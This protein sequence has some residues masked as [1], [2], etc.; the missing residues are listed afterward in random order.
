MRFVPLGSGS[1]G[2]ST[3]VEFAAARILVDAGLSARDLAARLRRVGVAPESID[4]ILLSHEHHDH[5]RGA[6]RFSTK[7]G[8]PVISAEET[9][10]AMDRSPVHFAEWIPLPEGEP[11]NLGPVRVEAFDVPHDAVRPVGFVL[12]GDGLRVG[13]ATDLGHPTTLVLQRLRGCHL[14]MVEA[15]HDPVLLR[16]G[17]YPWQLKQRVAS[18]VGHLSNAEAGAL[19]KHTVEAECRAVVLAHLS[20]KNN[21]AELARGAASRALA[22]TG[23]RPDVQVAARRAPTEPVQL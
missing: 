4:W 5:C 14:L 19:L 11:L 15:N 9:L 21:T 16:D 7:H 12:H 2:N 17:P 22:A 23:Y 18:R 13:V 20:E 3:L 8:V 1:Q 6:A 10:D